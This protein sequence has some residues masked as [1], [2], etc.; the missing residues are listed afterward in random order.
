MKYRAGYKYQLAEDFEV[1]VSWHLKPPNGDIR[2][3]FVSLIKR[4][5]FH[6]GYEIILRIK[7]GYAWDGPSGPM[8]DTPTAMTGSIIHD[9]LYQLIR[10]GHLPNED[11]ITRHAADAE[12]RKYCKKVGMEWWRRWYMYRALRRWAAYAAD[13]ENKR[14]VREAP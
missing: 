1:E 7:A 2:T 11:D 14:E 10:E 12:I 6:G 5:K 13:P 9:A 8:L 3:E 4:E